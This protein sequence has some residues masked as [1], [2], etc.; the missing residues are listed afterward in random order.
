MEEHL[1]GVK[2]ADT[3]VISS[4]PRWHQTA[5][6]VSRVVCWVFFWNFFFFSFFN[7]AVVYLLS[8]VINSHVSEILSCAT[9]V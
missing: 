3:D 2:K 8:D 1:F 9:N 4:K 7:E 5:I 6:L